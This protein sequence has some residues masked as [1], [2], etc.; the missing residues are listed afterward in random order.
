MEFRKIAVCRIIERKRYITEREKLMM[1]IVIF[2]AALI[3]LDLVA[4]RWGYDSRDG[5]TSCEWT[6]KQ[7]WP[8]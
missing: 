7:S 1:I 6:R 5:F 3:V 2:I 8:Y 4:Q